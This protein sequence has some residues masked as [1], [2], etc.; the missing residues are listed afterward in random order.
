MLPMKLTTRFISIA[1]I[2]MLPWLASAQST[3][4]QKDDPKALAANFMEQFYDAPA[5]TV[6][7]TLTD[8]TDTQTKAVASVNGHVCVM[9]M[10]KAP[11][12]VHAPFGWLVG[13]MQCGSGK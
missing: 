2:A 3:D 8:T 10:S 6:M 7:V 11:E 13:S 1:S 12:G 5:D 9:D 4:Q